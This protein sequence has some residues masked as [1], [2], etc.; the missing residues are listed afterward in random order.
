MVTAVGSPGYGLS[1]QHSSGA[2]TLGAS[3]ASLQGRLRQAQSQLDDWTTCVSAK[4][5]KGQAA[6]QKLSGEVSATKEQIANQLQLQAATT[7]K[8]VSSV[9]Q[10]EAPREPSASTLAVRGRHASIDVWA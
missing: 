9:P 2:N 7:S 1:V 5:V 10:T 8:A 3:V 6:I 4:T